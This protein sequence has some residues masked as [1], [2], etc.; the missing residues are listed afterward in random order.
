MMIGLIQRERKR[1]HFFTT[2]NLRVPL[3]F[4]VVN[5]SRTLSHSRV[6]SVGGTVGPGTNI[7]VKDIWGI[8]GSEPSET[9]MVFEKI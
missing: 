5:S 8:M 3:L 6:V 2:S 4:F 7:I 1:S 9:L